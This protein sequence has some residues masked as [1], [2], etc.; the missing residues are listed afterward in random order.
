M[1]YTFIV[2][3]SYYGAF[4]RQKMILRNVDIKERDLE[5]WITESC[6]VK[7]STHY[8]LT[9]VGLEDAALMWW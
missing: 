6:G 2:S 7:E 1:T 5:I 3:S 9:A 8:R 4:L